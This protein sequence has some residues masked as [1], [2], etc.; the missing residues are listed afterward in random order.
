MSDVEESGSM[1][2]GASGRPS[3]PRMLLLVW[4]ACLP[5]A[6]HGDGDPAAPLR[7]ALA[8]AC[9]APSA[10]LA[11]MAARIPGATGVAEEPL[12]VRGTEIGWERRFALP[13]GAEIR[14]ERFAPRGQLRRLAVEYWTAVPGGGT[15]PRLAAIADAG[16][17]IRLGRRLLYEPDAPQPVAL[18]H[19]DAALEATGER[20]PLNPA[21]PDGTDPG[22]VPVALVD[23]GVNY[24]LPQI[25]R[26]LARDDAGAIL[27]HDYWDMDRR[28]FDAN[29]A[30]SPFFPQRH[31][32][33]TASLLL[34]EAPAVRLV[35]Y[36]YPRPDM[37]RMRA[38]IADAASKGIVIVNVS[39]GSGERGEW[40]AFAQAAG[41][42]PDMLFVVSAG[43]NGRD[44]D[45][46]PVY[47]AALSLDNAITVTSSLAD[48]ELARGSNWGS[49]SV[50]LLVPAE[51]LGVTGFDGSE[52]LVSGSSYAA[53]RVSA[54]A[55]RLLARHPDWRAAELKEAIFARVLPPFA[56][57]H[58]RVAEGFMPRPDKA[59]RLPLLAGEGEPG[60]V[61]RHT[62]TR[63]ELYP[64]DRPLSSGNIVFEPTFAYF[65]GGSW[66]R[67]ALRRHARRMAAILGQCGIT[68]PAIDVRVLEGADVYHYYH[69]TIAKELVR[70]VDL[71]KPT[72]YFVRDTLA[73]DAYDAVAIGKSNSATRPALRY[74]A[75]FTEDTRNPGIALAH[76]LVHI[77]MDSGRHVDT[78]ANLM[79]ADTAARNTGLTSEQCEAIVT[80]GTENGLLTEASG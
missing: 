58:G 52:T 51:R 65:E 61:A 4:I 19:L 29:P 44:I 42:H 53:V 67:G 7:Q 30:R 70:R 32:T 76:E 73:V 41:A 18:E 10:S 71:P 54:L 50:D 37:D 45:A 31:G 68:I 24:L 78:P 21:V 9:D 13:Q 25:G 72:V 69:D 64:A 15:R 40:E 34:R 74:T 11:R 26:R 5:V 63:A 27:G 80:R 35:P 14:I 46:A 62:F 38:L 75:W 43:N 59:E 12:V 20:E 47:P 6:A 8:A 49:A 79:R 16:C 60:V 48:G 39:M 17:T 57:A 56:G 66:N 33:R 1:H 23:A 2:R 22:G 28:P 3:F 55:A 36:R 77:L